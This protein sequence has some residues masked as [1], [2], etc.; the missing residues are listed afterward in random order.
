M[1]AWF[2]R[3]RAELAES[4]AEGPEQESGTPKLRQGLR[5]I[6][7][8]FED[9]PATGRAM[10]RAWLRAGGPLLSQDS[11]TRDTCARD[12]VGPAGW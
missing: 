1:L 11:E 12:S 5:T 2:E 7:R 3:R 10:V 8:L 6:A 4:L 9:D